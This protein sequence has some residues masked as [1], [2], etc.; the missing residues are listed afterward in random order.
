MSHVIKSQTTM[1][2]ASAKRKANHYVDN[3]LLYSYMLK[4]RRACEES[5]LKGLDKPRVPEYVGYAILQIASRL[6]LRP[7]FINYSFREEMVGDGIE[8]C[9]KYID[10]FDPDNYRNPFAYFTQVIYFAFLRRIKDEKKQSYIRQK[11]LQNAVISGLVN[12]YQD[13]DGDQMGMIDLDSDYM[14][15]VVEDFEKKLQEEKLKKP[16][17]AKKKP[18]LFEEK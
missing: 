17:K 2:K 7:N 16:V 11:S 10:N 4:Y 14:S 3:A 9:I 8:N 5:V 1:P 15:S 13:G 18:D 6:S 12:A